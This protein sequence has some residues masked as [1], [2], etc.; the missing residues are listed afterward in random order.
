VKQAAQTR[1][2]N[3]PQ[4]VLAFMAREVTV[5]VKKLLLVNFQLTF[6]IASIRS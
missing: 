1:S 3:G 6:Y 4:R 5:Q 2:G